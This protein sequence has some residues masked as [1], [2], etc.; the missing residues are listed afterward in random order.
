MTTRLFVMLAGA[1]LLAPALA[2]AEVYKWVDENGQVHYSDR[3]TAASADKVNVQAPPAPQAT[4]APPPSAGSGFPTTPEE[5]EAFRLK[6][7]YAQRRDEENARR[8]REQE[9][10]MRQQ[11]KRRQEQIRLQAEEQEQARRK[12]VIEECKATMR[13]RICSQGYD[14][15]MRE[16]Q[17]LASERA[18]ADMKARQQPKY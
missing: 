5:H 8:F 15:I 14:A 12:A 7:E 9:E 18:L 3:A 1:I 4:P 6:A 16:K 11:E 17:R 13:L 2:S 10:K